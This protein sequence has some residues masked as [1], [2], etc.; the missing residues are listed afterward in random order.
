MLGFYQFLRNFS[1]NLNEK[2]LPFYRLLKKDTEIVTDKT[3]YQALQTLNNYLI[4]ATEVILRLAKPDLQYVILTD[5]SYHQAGFV[6]LI[7]DYSKDPY[8]TKSKIKTNAPVSFGSKLFITAQLK[9]S[10]FCK[11]FFAVYFELD[12]FSQYVWGAEKPIII[13]T[14]NQTLTR[15]FKTKTIQLSVWSFIDQVLA[16]NIVVGNIPTQPRI[17]CPEW[18]LTHRRHLN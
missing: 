1:P 2:L 9:F 15:F 7:E 10:I 8:N 13:K 5:A 18:K 11:E 3:L 16:F 12:H 17:F 6:F 14:D 4:K